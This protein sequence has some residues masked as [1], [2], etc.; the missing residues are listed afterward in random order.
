MSDK[1]KHHNDPDQDQLQ[2]QLEAQAQGQLQGQ[3][4]LNLQGQGQGQGQGQSQYESQLAAQGVVQ[5]AGQYSEND[6]KNENENKNA[7]ESKNENENS[8]ENKLENS[9]DNKVENKLDNSVDNKV[10]NK[11]ENNVETNVDVDVDVKV[12]LDLSGLDF[13][14]EIDVEYLDGI[15]FKMPDE[16]TQG[17]TGGGTATNFNLDQVNNLVDNDSLTSPSVA[18]NAGGYADYYSDAD[19]PP[20]LFSQTATADGGYAKIESATASIH[21][22]DGASVAADATAAITQ[23]AFTQSIV[24]GANIQF[25]SVTLSIVGNDSISDGVDPV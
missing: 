14:P 21:D 11:I 15:L 12:D 5:A 8:N 3:G 23:D 2:A 17:I 18:F 6:S 19:A 10:E 9:V 25:N 16:V 4:Q 24:M 22:G 20:A 1:K 7:N 13:K